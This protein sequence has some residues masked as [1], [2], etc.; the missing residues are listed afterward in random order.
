MV[1]AVLIAME[2]FTRHTMAVQT[3]VQTDNPRQTAVSGRGDTQA[4][5]SVRQR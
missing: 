2:Q 1:E 5:C 3:S 4:D